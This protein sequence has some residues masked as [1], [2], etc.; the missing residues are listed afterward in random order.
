[1]RAAIVRGATSEEQV[2]NYLPSNYEVRASMTSPESGKLYVRIWGEDKAGWTLEGYVIPR[3]ESGLLWAEEY[4]SPGIQN[5]FEAFVKAAQH[6]VEEAIQ[7]TMADLDLTCDPSEIAHD[8]IMAMSEDWA[9]P[10]RA[11]VFR[12]A[13]IER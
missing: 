11:E 10:I 12:R 8:V 9:Y 5:E 2:A 7:S 6:D 1:M 3:L 4:D 13:G